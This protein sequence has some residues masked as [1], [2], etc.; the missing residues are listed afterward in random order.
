MSSTEFAACMD[1]GQQQQQQQQLAVEYSTEILQLDLE[2]LPSESFSAS[3][4]MT[5]KEKDACEKW[6]LWRVSQGSSSFTRTRQH[7][8][9]KRKARFSPNVVCGLFPTWI[10]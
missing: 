8:L 7:V 2:N 10:C 3:H 1:T 4:N 5:R 9:I 6:L